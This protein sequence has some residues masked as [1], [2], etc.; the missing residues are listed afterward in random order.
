MFSLPSGVMSLYVAIAARI[1]SAGA[2]AAAA[3][4]AGAGAARPSKYEII[5]LTS[6]VS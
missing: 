4:P 2:P 6:G 5:A 3:A 1:C